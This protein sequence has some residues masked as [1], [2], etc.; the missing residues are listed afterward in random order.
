MA[1]RLLVIAAISELSCYLAK[2]IL[3]RE[4][5]TDYTAIR[6]FDSYVNLIEKEFDHE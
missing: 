3:V 6:N 4:N 1:G 5:L 2:P